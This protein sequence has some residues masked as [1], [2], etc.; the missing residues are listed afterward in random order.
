M[1]LDNGIYVLLTE[2]EEGPEYRVTYASAIDN[3]YGE[4]NAETAKYDGNIQAIEETFGNVPVLHTLN[5][6]LD[7]AEELENNM[8]PTEDGVCVINEFKD[9]GYIFK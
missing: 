8:E 1:S 5:E 2:T 6:A 3:I 7:F 4:W 9:Y